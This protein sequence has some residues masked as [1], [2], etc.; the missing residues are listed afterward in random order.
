MLAL[1]FG[2]LLM[3]AGASARDVEEITTQVATGLGADRTELRV[4]YASL[5]ITIGIGPDGITR[6]RKVGPLGVNQSLDYALRGAAA[7]IERGGFTVAEARAE[8]DRLVRATPRHADWVVAVAVGVACAAFGRLLGVDWAGVAPIFAGSTLAQMMRRQLALRKF[9]VFV[10]AT[11]VAFLGSALCGLGGRWT[12]S[13]TV[14]LD[15]TVPVLL[16]VPGVPSLN[17]QN[18]ILEGRPT[19]GSARAV[20]VA[21]ILVFITAGVWLA[22]GLLGEGH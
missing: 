5:A 3:E 4:G 22:Q 8:L 20:W 1:E 12:G 19:L 15:M 11:V 21:V 13:T 10:S 18:D 7:R 6:M 9:N 14:A 16:L 17:A 2:W